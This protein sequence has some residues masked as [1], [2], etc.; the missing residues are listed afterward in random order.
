MVEDFS[1]LTASL[2]AT[3]QSSITGCLNDIDVSR[4]ARRW[5]THLAFWAGG[6][7]RAALPGLH[8]RR[9]WPAK[10]PMNVRTDYS[11]IGLRPARGASSALASSIPALSQFLA[12]LLATGRGG[13]SAIM[14]MSSGLP[15]GC[16]T[17]LETSHMVRRPSRRH[18]RRTLCG[19]FHPAQWLTDAP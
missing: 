12:N 2:E 13:A 15:C 18:W 1:H 7:P 5:E 9:R 4:R 6:R 11:R 10:P 16:K 8:P 3:A 17:V 14:A 19:Q